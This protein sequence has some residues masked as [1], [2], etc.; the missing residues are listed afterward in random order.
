MLAAMI[1]VALLGTVLPLLWSVAVVVSGVASAASRSF[2]RWEATMS[3]H[4][5]L[6]AVAMGA[7]LVDHSG[8]EGHAHAAL[9]ASSV[10]AVLCVVVVVGGALL[11]AARVRSRTTPRQRI[12]VLEPVLMAAAVGLMLVR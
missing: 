8:A 11:T 6:A 9:D 7:L 5:G 4:R 10:I 2:E 12:A 3:A 1:D